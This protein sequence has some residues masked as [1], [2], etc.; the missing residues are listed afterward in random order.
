MWCLCSLL[1][2]DIFLCVLP[3]QIST[4]IWFIRNSDM[5]VSTK[6]DANMHSNSSFQL[7]LTCFIVIAIVIPNRVIYANQGIFPSLVVKILTHLLQITDFSGKLCVF[8]TFVSS[9]VE[10]AMNSDHFNFSRYDSLRKR[11]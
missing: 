4:P 8:T 9:L 5:A 2:N 6:G 3:L 1:F 7:V 11:F 10:I